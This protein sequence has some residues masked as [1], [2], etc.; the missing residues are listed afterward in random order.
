MLCGT[1]RSRFWPNLRVSF[2]SFKVYS[3]L[4]KYIGFKVINQMVTL[5]IF[6]VSSKPLQAISFKPIVQVGKCLIIFPSLEDCFSK[7][8]MKSAGHCILFS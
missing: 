8:H 4:S 2:L 5:S 3:I 6:L 1:R 7:N